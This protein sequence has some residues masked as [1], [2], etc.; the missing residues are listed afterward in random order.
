[1]SQIVAKHG[2]NKVG[3]N[4]GVT[5]LKI[6]QQF[7]NT[8]V[9]LNIK[10]S[11]ENNSTN[12]C[13]TGQ[14]NMQFHSFHHTCTCTPWLSTL[15]GCEHVSKEIE[16]IQRLIRSKVMHKTVSNTDKK[17]WYSTFV[18]LHVLD[19]VDHSLIKCNVFY[20]HLKKASKSQ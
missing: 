11:L 14:K 9:K 7:W 1:M 4:W 17:R 8:K 19:N 10:S 15:K 2:Q 13:Q 12:C 5:K 20:C 6:K 16:V 18:F 3:L